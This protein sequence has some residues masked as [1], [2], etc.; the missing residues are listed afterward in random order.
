MRWVAVAVAAIL[1]TGCAARVSL[2]SQASGARGP[3][4]ELVALRGTVERKTTASGARADRLKT[5]IKTVE[6][7]EALEDSLPAIV[8]AAIRAALAAYGAPPVTAVPAPVPP[9]PARAA[10][11]PRE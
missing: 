9:R 1:S 2:W 10:I 4:V 11:G 6:L 5:D 3:A 7:A 8:E